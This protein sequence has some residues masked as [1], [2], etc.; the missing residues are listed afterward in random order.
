MVVTE[1]TFAALSRA[2]DAERHDLR[3]QAALL[4][5]EGLHHR[6]LLEKESDTNGPVD[7]ADPSRT[8]EGVDSIISACA[9]LSTQGGRHARA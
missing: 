3:E 6:G 7:V 8:G 4:I 1:D 2:A 5:V 9:A